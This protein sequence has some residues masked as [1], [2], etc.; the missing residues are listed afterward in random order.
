M[1]MDGTWIIRTVNLYNGE[2]DGTEQDGP[3]ESVEV[4]FA[5]GPYGNGRSVELDLSAKTSDSPIVLEVYPSSVVKVSFD[6]E[7]GKVEKILDPSTL[8]DEDP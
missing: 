6:T 2:V 4:W 3:T 5:K 7:G 8:D 1:T